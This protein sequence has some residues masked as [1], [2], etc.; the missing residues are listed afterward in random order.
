[1]KGGN[2]IVSTDILD[3]APAVIA[4]LMLAMAFSIF[5]YDR[6]FDNLIGLAHMSVPAKSE[7]I[8]MT[9]IVAIAALPLA[10]LKIWPNAVLKAATYLAWLIYLPSVL[11]FSGIDVFRILSMS[12]NFEIFT[13]GLSYTVIAIVGI[14]LACGSLAGR[15]FGRLKNAREYFTSQGADKYEARRALYHNALFEIK[16]IAASGIATVIFAFISSAA[17]QK[18]QS[19]FT[20]AGF[21]YLLVGLGAIVLLALVFL[22][23][24]WPH[25]NG[26][27]G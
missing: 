21:M 16:L 5:T 20:S 11:Y 7:I 9:V 10:F 17:G 23:F 12:A 2:S 1:M 24:L 22:L 27:K 19:I 25:K 4:I 14:L 18:L 15:S 3:V 6:L 13:S 26:E 8:W